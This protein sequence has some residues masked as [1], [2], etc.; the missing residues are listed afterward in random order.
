MYNKRKSHKIVK[1]NKN[2]KANNTIMT[3]INFQIIDKFY[4]KKWKKNKNQNT[5]R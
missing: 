2:F 5:N 3:Y 4:F 1:Y